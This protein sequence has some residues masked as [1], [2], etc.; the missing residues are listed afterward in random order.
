LLVLDEAA[1]PSPEEDDDANPL[2]CPIN[3]YDTDP[4]MK[5][6]PVLAML[7]SRKL[8]IGRNQSTTKEKGVNSHANKAGFVRPNIFEKRS[9]S[10][11]TL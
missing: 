4:F 6:N 9:K 2:V 11:S 7:F 10:F 3:L 1:H 5:V 8:P